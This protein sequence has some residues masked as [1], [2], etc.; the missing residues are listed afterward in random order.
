LLLTALA[1]LCLSPRNLFPL[2]LLLLFGGLPLGLLPLT[3]RD[4]I[5]GRVMCCS[6]GEERI[7]E[8]SRLLA[9]LQRRFCRGQLLLC[10]RLFVAVEHIG[11]FVLFFVVLVL[12]CVLVECL[13]LLVNFGLDCLGFSLD[14][15]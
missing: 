5:S 10:V 11:T 6:L 8:V 14:V 7:V 1:N 13:F 12:C 4:T 2:P 15:L 3:R 9:D